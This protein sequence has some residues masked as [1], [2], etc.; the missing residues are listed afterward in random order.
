MEQTKI[1]ITRGVSNQTEFY[2]EFSL[3]VLGIITRQFMI[4]LIGYPTN[5]FCISCL[6]E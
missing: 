4:G 1:L 2:I 6:Y 3:S 5:D